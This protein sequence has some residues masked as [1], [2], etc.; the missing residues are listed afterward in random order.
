[1]LIL[2]YFGFSQLILAYLELMV[3]IFT[4]VLI[5]TQKLTR[6]KN[7]RFF[8]SFGSYFLGKFESLFVKNHGSYK[9]K[10][11]VLWGGRGVFLIGHLRH[12]RIFLGHAKNMDKGFQQYSYKNGCMWLMGK[13]AM[14]CIINLIKCLK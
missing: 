4:V 12:L 11:M 8:K 1:M 6:N 14:A 3:L 10:C 7:H 5:S 13:D 2:V 9:N